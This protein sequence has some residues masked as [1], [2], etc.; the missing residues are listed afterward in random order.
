MPK[1]YNIKYVSSQGVEVDLNG[2]PYIWES[3]DLLSYEWD[4]D[5][6]INN[7]GVGAQITRFTRGIQDRTIELTVYNADGLSIDSH[8]AYLTGLFETDVLAKQPGYIEIGNG[9]INCYVTASEKVLY[10][11]N[12][13]AK[14]ILNISIESPFWITEDLHRFNP[15]TGSA[16]TGFILP[17]ALPFG[18]TALTTRTLIN[19]HYAACPAF[20]TMYGPATDP[21]FTVNS[22]V[23]K[24]T[25]TLIAGERFEI[26]QAAKTVT[27]IINTGEQFNYFKYRGKTYSVFEPIPKGE[28]NIYYDNS[29]V[30]DI[31]L[32]K[33]RSEPLWSN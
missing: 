32:M 7:N 28:N 3:T 33:E 9:Y 12:K 17:L 27:K 1:R 19:D 20:I 31:L 26:D 2:R 24:V 30:F 4:K 5:S 18:L 8:I 16:S 29:F 21:E 25:G 6:V 11:N 23:Y 13:I 10:R 15:L 14:M 22:H